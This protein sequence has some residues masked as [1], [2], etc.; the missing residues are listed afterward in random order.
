MV[1][2]G[3]LRKVF[4]AFEFFERIE[5][6]HEAYTAC[7]STVTGLKPTL[8]EVNR[9]IQQHSNTPTQNKLTYAA[10]AQ[11]RYPRLRKRKLRCPSTRYFLWK[12]QT[13]D[14]PTVP[15]CQV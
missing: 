11:L 10:Y 15:K 3:N 14:L 8:M 1:A 13:A 6:I 12:T 4:L 9:K 5:G 7:E 2:D